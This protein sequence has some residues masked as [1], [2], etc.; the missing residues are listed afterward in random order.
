MQN[1]SDGIQLPIC[2]AM[3]RD[4]NAND[5]NLQ[6]RKMR[7]KTKVISIIWIRWTAEIARSIRISLWTINNNIN[8]T[9]WQ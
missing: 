3:R 6:F 5:D 8:I 7:R 4:C 2:D 1:Q 9:L